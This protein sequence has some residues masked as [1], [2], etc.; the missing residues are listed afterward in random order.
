M[1][2]SVK[3]I[4]I[5]DTDLRENCAGVKKKPGGLPPGF[6]YVIDVPGS[7]F[8]DPSVGTRGRPTGALFGD[9]TDFAHLT[10]PPFSAVVTRL[11]DFKYCSTSWPTTPIN[12][13][14]PG[15]RISYESL[16]LVS[17]SPEGTLQASLSC[18]GLL[19]ASELLGIRLVNSQAAH[20]MITCNPEHFKDRLLL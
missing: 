9:R 20:M 14:A 12:A 5:C 8:P 17:T 7:C 13:D 15:Y 6:F 4:S 16:I 19:T 11:A 10:S 3:Q 2:R 18:K 1:R